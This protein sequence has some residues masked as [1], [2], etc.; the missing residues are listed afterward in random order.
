MKLKN[1]DINEYMLYDSIFIKFK[2]QQNLFI[3]IELRILSRACVVG[4]CFCGIGIPFL[5]GED[6]L[7]RRVH[8]VKIHLLYI[9]EVC[10]FLCKC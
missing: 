9:Y 7:N 2:T 3:V 10:T 8:F 5:D 1:P 4:W 6:W